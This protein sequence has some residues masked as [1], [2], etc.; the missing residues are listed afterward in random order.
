LQSSRLSWHIQ[1]GVAQG[2]P[3]TYGRYLRGV[4]QRRLS[5]ASSTFAAKFERYGC[6]LQLDVT[7]S[8]GRQAKRPVFLCILI[9]ADSDQRDFKKFN[10]RGENFFPGKAPE[11]SN[12]PPPVLE[13]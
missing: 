13:F 9:V 8:H 10:N 6:T 11:G 7:I 5:Y 12:P 3:G 2:D 1:K 4:D